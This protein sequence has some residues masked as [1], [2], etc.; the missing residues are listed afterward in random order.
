MK[1]E[2]S[3][4]SNNGKGDSPRNC[5]S[6]K[7]KEKELYYLEIISFEWTVIC[8]FGSVL[9]SIIFFVDVQIVQTFIE[10]E[11]PEEESLDSKD[12]NG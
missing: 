9:A 3:Q 5:F 1:K 2:T 12:K 8:L 7:Y 4:S 6:K 11:Q 10:I